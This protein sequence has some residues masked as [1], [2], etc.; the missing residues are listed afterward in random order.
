MF[1]KTA[2][3][4]KR[5]VIVGIIVFVIG[6]LGMCVLS[7]QYFKDTENDNLLM[8]AIMSVSFGIIVFFILERI[9]NRRVRRQFT[10]LHI[11]KNVKEK[12]D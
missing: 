2:K 10:N 5:M 7:F 6:L 11:V 4:S 3:S 9:A 1:T 12:T 8:Y